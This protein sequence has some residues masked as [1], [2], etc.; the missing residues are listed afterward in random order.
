MPNNTTKA[1][2]NVNQGENF[3]VYADEYIE[4]AALNTTGTRLSAE[5]IAWGAKCIDDMIEQLY[6][7]DKD[8]LSKLREKG[9][10]PA[11]GFLIDGKPADLYRTGNTLTN[12]LNEDTRQGKSKIL[13]NALN[14]KEIG[15]I[16]YG[17]DKDGNLKP[18]ETVPVT[19][20]LSKNIKDKKTGFFRRIFEAL[21]ILSPKLNKRVNNAN[22]SKRNYETLYQETTP[23]KEE[24]EKFKNELAAAKE[25]Q[26]DNPN[27]KVPEK[28]QQ[29]LSAAERQTISARLSAEVAKVRTLRNQMD[30]DFFGD[31]FETKQ[32]KSKTESINA[33][34]Q[35]K[36]RLTT[37]KHYND[38]LAQD[39]STATSKKP[40]GFNALDTMSTSTRRTNLAILYAMTQGISFDE[41]T[42]PENTA[43]R[44]QMG[45]KFMKEMSTMSFQEFAEKNKIEKG[46]DDPETK[47]AYQEYYLNQTAKI[48]KFFCES[49]DAIRKESYDLPNPND[50]NDIIQKYQKYDIMGAVTQDLTQSAVWL[51]HPKNLFEDTPVN[52]DSKQRLNAVVD[53]VRA[54]AGPL[55]AAHTATSDYVAFL[56]SPDFSV[57]GDNYSLPTGKINLAARGKAA[58]Q[59]MYDSTHDKDGKETVD[60]LA[61]VFDNPELSQKIVSFRAENGSAFTNNKEIAEAAFNNY[62][63]TNDPEMATVMYDENN[64]KLVFFS[65]DASENYNIA[66]TE[67]ADAYTMNNTNAQKQ[68]DKYF[69]YDTTMTFTDAYK[70]GVF[71]HPI[72]EAEKAAKETYYE[73]VYAKIDEGF[74]K[75]AA[76]EAM[77]KEQE[78]KLAAEKNR[79]LTEAEKAAK[80]RNDYIVNAMKNGAS[81]EQAEKLWKEEEH[82]Q[83]LDKALDEIMKE[84]DE[85]QKTTTKTETKTRITRDEL[86]GNPKPKMNMPTSKEKQSPTKQMGMSHS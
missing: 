53:Y 28:P 23:N 55:G 47:N 56:T 61:R 9:I 31:Q 19:T 26:L 50:Y 15:L 82:S 7:N 45:E 64:K 38:S 1:V 60:C 68:I 29:M 66:M 46:L 37:L 13:A 77:K 48:E 30:L 34:I 72:S 18:Q 20:N 51:A 44:K 85:L 67:T 86:M 57:S 81:L 69:A 36:F 73:D 80:E 58:L 10:D 76:E 22:N 16:K 8:V 12:I 4:K 78:E 24:K 75:Q 63:R 62:L 41:I 40:A 65:N 59:V 52:K 71:A 79:P 74:K 33:Q 49:Y 35:D 11:S 5:E 21:G 27:V 70:D 2:L 6:A 32:G 84:T 42:K 39:K 17:F 54:K 25:K 43:L 14:G 3:T 83:K